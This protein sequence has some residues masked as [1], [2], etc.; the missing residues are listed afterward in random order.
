MSQDQLAAAS[1]IDSANIRSYESGRALPALKSLVQIATALSV[2][3][4]D[5]LD[6]LT[7]ADFPATR[8]RARG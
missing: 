4:G 5:L 7:L 2:E 8:Q 3:P 6:G 1:D